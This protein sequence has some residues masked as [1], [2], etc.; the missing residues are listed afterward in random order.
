MVAVNDIAVVPCSSAEEN[1]EPSL[2][3]YYEVIYEDADDANAAT[4]T[5]NGA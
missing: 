2:L 5:L 1:C 4:Q 3:V